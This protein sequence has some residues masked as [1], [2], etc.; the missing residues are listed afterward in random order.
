MTF[1]ARPVE[2][3]NR[4][5]AFIERILLGQVYVTGTAVANIRD[6]TVVAY[7]CAFNQAAALDTPGDARF[8]EMFIDTAICHDAYSKVPLVE[9]SLQN[10]TQARSVLHNIY[11]IMSNF[12]DVVLLLIYTVGT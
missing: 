11:K 10:Q 1:I 7:Q 8:I 9:T 6:N 12:G 4:N 3:L 2:H 5:P